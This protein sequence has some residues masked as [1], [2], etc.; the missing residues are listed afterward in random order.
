MSASSNLTANEQLALDPSK[1]IRQYRAAFANVATGKTDLR[2]VKIALVAVAAKWNVASEVV[3]MTTKVMRRHL[4][5]VLAA[6]DVGTVK[7]VSQGVR[8][9]SGSVDKGMVTETDVAVANQ[10]SSTD[11]KLDALIEAVA[12]LTAAIIAGK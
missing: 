5:S 11:A 9:T 10:A 2:K 4:N 6:S 1:N 3:G 7:Q 12:G 8:V